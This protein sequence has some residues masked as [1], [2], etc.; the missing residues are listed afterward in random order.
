MMYRGMNALFTNEGFETAFARTQKEK[1]IY[2]DVMILRGGGGKSLNKAVKKN[3][4]KF[5]CVMCVAMMGPW[6]VKGC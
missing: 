3:R 1:R 4:N 2:W 5:L 6:V